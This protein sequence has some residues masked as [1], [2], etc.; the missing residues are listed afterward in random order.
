MLSRLPRGFLRSKGSPM[1]THSDM[2]T[3]KRLLPGVFRSNRDTRLF[4][5]VAAAQNDSHEYE[6][7]AAAVRSVVDHLEPKLSS[8]VK[9]G[10]RVFL[11]VNM[12]CSGYR[13]PEER[14]TSHPAYVQA[15]I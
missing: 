1:T 12:G 9:H 3:P 15:I 10:D 2:L 11:K 14:Y 5:I 6:A 13:Q 8:L 7:V 4:A